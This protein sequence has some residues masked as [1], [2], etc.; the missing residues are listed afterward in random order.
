MHTDAKIQ[1]LDLT[2]IKSKPDDDTQKGKLSSH[3]EQCV[4][5]R[6]HTRCLVS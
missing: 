6:P 1:T 5:F 3:E 4:G 2:V